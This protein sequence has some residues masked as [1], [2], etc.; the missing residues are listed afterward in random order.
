MDKR[1]VRER[2]FGGR[3]PSKQSEGR[4][5][6][7]RPLQA[8][9]INIPTDTSRES[10]SDV[11][12]SLE[13]RGA[14]G[15]SAGSRSAGSEGQQSTPV[16]RSLAA[17][18]AQ[19]AT[20]TP[21]PSFVSGTSI[22][23]GS[24]ETDGEFQRPRAMCEIAL[25]S[26]LIDDGKR[27]RRYAPISSLSQ[28]QM[29]TSTLVRAL[30]STRSIDAP[31]TEPTRARRSGAA[32]LGAGGNFEFQASFADRLG[33]A[34]GSPALV[35]PRADRVR[36]ILSECR[37]AGNRSAPGSKAHQAKARFRHDFEAAVGQMYSMGRRDLLQR[38]LIRL[39]NQDLPQRKCL[40]RVTRPDLCMHRHKARRRN[41]STL[42]QR[43]RKAPQKPRRRHH[44]TGDDALR[45]RV[46]EGVCRSRRLSSL[47]TLDV[48]DAKF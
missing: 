8:L 48:R 44:R 46:G 9:D 7:K 2:G 12:G 32:P 22:V 43:W 37:P 36:M 21:Q 3:Y 19:S 26:E 23:P 15:T 39:V 30:C 47:P 28:M 45:R 33:V 1:K 35:Q 6:A 13:S 10:D 20:A 31:V 27:P 40:C 29:A 41:P 34:A 42:S 38:D 25:P 17:R 5:T 4:K 16:S 11:R 14:S 18:L 24:L